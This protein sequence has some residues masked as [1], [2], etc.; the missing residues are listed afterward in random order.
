MKKFGVQIVILFILIFASADGFAQCGATSVS[1]VPQPVM[2]CEGNTELIS[3]SATGSCGGAYEFE[4]LDGAAVVQAWS[5]STSFNASPTVSTT[6]TV[7]ARCNACPAVVVSD[8]FSVQ[9]TEEPTVTGNLFLCSGG[10]T[11]LTGSGSNGTLEWW[12]DSVG[13]TQI[14]ATEIYNSPSLASTT[15]Y[16]IHASTTA[17]GGTGSILITECG[18]DG[19]IGGTGSEDYI[20]VSNLYTTPVNTAGWVVAVSNSYSNI[21]T[22]N[23]ILWNLPASFSPCSVVTRTDASGAAN[24]WGNNIFWNST[25]SSW[26]IIID[27]V[28]NVVDFIAWGWTA[29]QLAAFNPT[30]NGFSISLG[31]E[32]VGNGCALPCGSAGGVQY[33]FARV[34]NTDNNASGD[35]ICQP[36]SVDV[37]N[38]GLTCGW[39]TSA[40]CPYP[41]TVVVD[42]APTASNPA[43]INVECIADVPT[44]DITVVTDEADDFTPSPAVTFLSDVSNGSTCPEVITR[45]Y[46]VTDSCSNYTD[47]TQTITINDITPPVFA[48]PPANL[49]VQCSADIP[50]MV[51]LGWTDNCD[52][53]GSVAGTDVSDGNSCAEVITRTWTYTDACGNVSSVSQTITIDDTTPPTA[54]NPQAQ[55][56]VTLPAPDPSIVND[57]ADNCGTPVVAFVSDIS[58][59]GFCPEIV[60][61]TY[62]VTD[63]CANETLV[64]Q[65]LT[66]GDPSPDASFLFSPIYLTNLATHVDFENTSTGAVSYVWDFGD[67]SPVSNEIDPSHDFPNEEGGAY[68]IELIAY[69]PMGC[70]DTV[71]MGISIKEELIYYIP[72]SFTPD[73]DE[74]NQTF[75]PVFTSGFDPYD[76]SMTIYNRWGELIFETHDATIGWDGTYKGELVPAGAY[77]WTITIKIADVD[78]REVMTGHVNILR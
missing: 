43:A 34:G 52:G 69:S 37:V 6:Y 40:T 39:T 3:L 58:D 23:N 60:T 48:A 2:I 25:S 55:Q 24:Y 47:V 22:Y 41:V 21:N 1:A 44:P 50:A 10:S 18:L 20:E 35:F 63:D 59:G 36:T 71:Q 14:S 28:G 51:N 68:I 46:R 77:V 42:V 32:W 7:N 76:F 62:S 5:G 17:S 45:T 38:P 29:A 75:Q 61:R 13:G 11:T 64:T 65:L 56:S 26:A 74:Y 33:S 4:I 70:T 8:T 9:V 57:A 73:G 54:S 27:D 19:A 16:W 67:G 49:T 30:I 66:I 53:S 12:S 15:T 72:N 31:T 78:D